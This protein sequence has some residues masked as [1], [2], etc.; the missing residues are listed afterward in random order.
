MR[1]INNVPALVKLVVE[2][3]IF[4]IVNQ[5][6]EDLKLGVN[7]NYYRNKIDWLAASSGKFQQIGEIINKLK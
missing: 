1:I 2:E 7:K 3:Q 5:I 6:I 4:F